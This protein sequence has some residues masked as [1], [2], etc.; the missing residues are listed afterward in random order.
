MVCVIGLAGAFLIGWL[1]PALELLAFFLAFLVVVGVAGVLQALVERRW[2]F[3]IALPALALTGMGVLMLAEDLALADEGRRTE[4]V[5]AEHEVTVRHGANGTTYT[6][7]YTLEY[8]DG[9]PLGQQ[10]TYRGKS[11]YEG[12][13][14][15][16]SITVLVDP[17]GKAR[18]R[19]ADDVDVRADV[20]VLTVGV[21]A[22]AGMCTACLV[23]TRRRARTLPQP[24]IR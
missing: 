18:V 4:V 10:M 5:V 9:R 15:G 23:S 24:G 3:W 20:A 6:H 12:V 1:L 22:T 13:A 16:A 7:T 17:A 2:V 11:G 19:P 21:L 8:P 14:E